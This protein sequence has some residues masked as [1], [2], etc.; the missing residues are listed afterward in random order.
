MVQASSIQ[1]RSAQDAQVSRRFRRHGEILRAATGLFCEKGYHE[2]TMEEIAGEMG[3][4]KGTIYNYF[5]SK[6]N[7]Y[8]EILK[9]SFEAIETLLQKEIENSDPAPLKLR[10]LLATIFTFY[11]RNWK[12]LRILSRDETH[13]LKE[14]FELTEKWRTRRVRLYERIIKKGI[15]EGSF[16][17]QNPRLRAL[18]LY[19]AVGAVMVHHDFSM[20]A[21]EVADAVFSQLASGLLVNKD[22]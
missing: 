13:L 19:G 1:E 15:N 11:R 4:S 20:D 9:E 8:L 12:V 18:M 5:S 7:L 10:K 17:E 6:E 22:S 21:G 16:V 14:H 2:V 3:V